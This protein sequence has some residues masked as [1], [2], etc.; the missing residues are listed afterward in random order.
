[1]IDSIPRHKK[2]LIFSPHPDDEV[3]GMGVTIYKIAQR[4][5]IFKIAYLTDGER[6]VF[7]NIP[8]YKKKKIRTKEAV[9]SMG[10]L[11][12]RE[13]DLV[14]L[15]LPF[16]SNRVPD[17]EDTEAVY[18]LLT[19]FM[20][21]IVFVATDR[22]P[23]STHIMGAQIIDEALVQYSIRTIIYCYKSV[24]ESFNKRDVNFFVGFDN[25]LMELKALSLKEHRSQAENPDFNSHENSLVQ[26]V[27]DR[28]MK[29]A[30]SLQLKEKYAE[31]FLRT[32]SL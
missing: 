25:H 31:G 30:S 26:R 32:E 11:G 13:K 22:D 6:G 16:Y 24:W 19:T 8:N 14:F 15:D 12:V 23:G 2:I 4:G 27:L 3:V 21:D 9:K 29:L 17:S 28:D 20:P 5:N 1:M 10:V 18:N 7:S